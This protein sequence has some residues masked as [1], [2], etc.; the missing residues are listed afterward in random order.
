MASQ[1]PE[2]QI[3]EL[4]KQAEQQLRSDDPE[5]P[6]RAR[7]VYGLARE[8]L[9][10][11]HALT[12]TSL[13]NLG[14][15]LLVST[16]DLEGAGLHLEQAL[17]I[18]RRVLGDRHPETAYT[19]YVL[20]ELLSRKGDLAAARAH[21]EQS[22]AVYREAGSDDERISSVL[23]SLAIVQANS[24]DPKAARL[25]F[26]QALVCCR[27][28]NGEEHSYFGTLLLNLGVLLS[29][30]GDL[31][32]ARSCFEQALTSARKTLGEDHHVT[33]ACL[34]NLRS[35]LESLG[36]REAARAHDRQA[37]AVLHRTVLGRPSLTKEKGGMAGQDSE[38]QITE[39]NN[40]VAELTGHREALGLAGRVCELARH[41]LGEDHPLTASSLN[42]LGTQLL[43]LEDLTGARPYLEQALAIR[44]R[45][46]G[47]NHPHT[48]HSLHNMGE[49]LRQLGDLARARPYLEQ[50]LAIYDRL[51][52]TNQIGT[53]PLLG[54]LGIL[55][56]AMGDFA[57]AGHSF[58]RALAIWR[59]TRGDD[60][61]QTATSLNNLG[62]LLFEAGD[63][64]AAR[65]YLEQALA[66]TCKTL[67]EENPQAA[68]S[69]NNLGG[70]LEQMGEWQAARAR[71][72]KALEIRLRV[73]GDHSHTAQSLHNV[74]SILQQIGDVEGALLHQERCV[75]IYRRALGE[76]H[77]AT[78]LSLAL[79][80][81][82]KAA[83]GQIDVAFAMTRKAA[84][85][86]DR[87]IAQVFSTGFDQQ[88]SLVL[89]K[90]LFNRERFLS[91]VSQH[92]SNSVE[93]VGAA[94]DLVLRRKGLS[95]EAL[96]TQRDAIL[97]GRY[98][99]LREP[100][101][102][103]AQLRQRIAQKTLAGPAPGES[104]TVHEQILDQWQ[105]D[106]QQR[107]T[108]LIRQIPEMNLEHQLQAADRRAVALALPADSALIEFVR[109]QVYDFKAVP[110]RGEARWR[111]RRYLAFVLLARD[112]DRVRMIDLGGAAPID[113]VIAEFRATVARDAQPRGLTGEPGARA[114]ERLRAALFDPLADALG[115]CK[116]LLLAPDGDL[117]RLPFEVLPLADGRRLIDEYRISYVS[118]GRDLLRFQVRSQRQPDEPLVAGD[119]D[120]DLHCQTKVAKPG[121]GPG[122][123]GR[124]FGGR[125]STPAPQPPRKE[126]PSPGATVV[127]HSR[128]LERS[129]W[130][131]G[132]LPGTRAE[133]Q[134]VAAQLGAQ[135]W[136]EREALEGKL[137]ARRSP[138][139]LHLATHGF[140]LPDQQPDPRQLGRNL[141][142]MGVSDSPGPGR[143]GG[144]GME[145]PMLRSGLALAGANTFLRGGALPEEA[146][147]GLLTAEDVAGMDLL[148]TDLVVLS[149]C[150]TGLGEVRTG[151][152]VFGLRRA[153]I[154]AGARTLVMSLWK[155]PD[156]A[157][158]F[159]MDRLYD[160]LLTRG[161]D[162]DLAL[163]D[164]QRATRDVTVGEL[165]AEWLSGTMIERLTAGDAEARRVLEELAW[166]PDGHRPFEHPFYWGAFICQ[167]D[168]APLPGSAPALR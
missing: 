152:G 24:G 23:G 126:T 128:E 124:V 149:A 127:R 112:P 57:V 11:D 67:G 49:L 9:G 76:D 101:E 56:Q 7:R 50:A 37:L 150:D 138:R 132:R 122:F 80:A 94:F 90:S 93:A 123:W 2:D 46:L 109:F 120:F 54:S 89:H 105:Q 146:E 22:L 147:D 87:I 73:L 17:Q 16:N 107:E 135:P 166:Q 162:R 156:L 91:L 113:Q 98:P 70:L 95:A 31:T 25:S 141:D 163:R 36:E 81:V 1:R 137:K 134:R 117:S 58:A 32:E 42:N 143:L 83:S 43:L 96:A 77:H 72:Q 111:E 21:L 144:P 55:S 165:R 104:L 59:K 38:Q 26:E 164:A 40:R 97:G 12:A 79:L 69:Y 66:I 148:G 168:T 52:D 136:I 35:L 131:F 86:D 47:E 129:Q 133:A 44:R 160:G 71:Y 53:A 28:A 14:F 3:D 100:F 106:Q 130:Y 13:H 5:A 45:V 41:V 60:D 33:V 78:G 92:L 142:L 102:Q 110:A 63:L 119:P 151:E 20:G 51:P 121:A 62:L 68:T 30:V 116:R 115:G 19:L 153:F 4:N 29:N 6:E 74:A 39:L 158:A 48:A 64:A 27:R 145:N 61:P 140:F 157:T 125:L 139:I 18:R 88:R 8:A 161:L 167:G 155:V 159:L 84:A 108:A 75:A 114:G 154:V 99:N 103:L 85:I 15:A 82:L 34:D 10:E 65:P 118:A